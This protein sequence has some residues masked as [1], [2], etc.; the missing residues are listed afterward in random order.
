MKNLHIIH[1]IYVGC[2]VK[3]GSRIKLTSQRFKHSVYIPYNSNNYDSLE[4]V[5]NW[6]KEKG[7]ECIGYGEGL[8]GYYFV[9][10][11]FKPLK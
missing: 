1:S 6:F 9:C 2:T 8:K 11:T 4:L 5:L 7:I 3:L 10:E